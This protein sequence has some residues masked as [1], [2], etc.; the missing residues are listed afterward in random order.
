VHVDGGPRVGERAP[1]LAH[2]A[3]VGSGNTPRFAAFAEDTEEGRR[4]LSK[5]S[6]FVEPAIRTPYHDGG[7]WLV[8][9]DG[10]VTL[11][12][13][14]G[15]WQEVDGYLARLQAPSAPQ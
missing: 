12:A 15:K 8:R 7:L 6:E 13:K 5:Y 4:V 2:E 11:V 10:Y 1:I 14:R 3:A 9:P